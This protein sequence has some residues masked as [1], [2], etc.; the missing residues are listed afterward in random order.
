LQRGQTEKL[1]QKILIFEF[2][3][4]SWE[5]SQKN[6]VKKILGIEPRMKDGALARVRAP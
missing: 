4:L 6:R 3:F 5:L 2:R 1:Q